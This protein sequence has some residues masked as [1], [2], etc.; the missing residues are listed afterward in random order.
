MNAPLSLKPGEPVG[1]ALRAI[2][3]QALSVTH[4]IVTD[5]GRD[6]ATAVHDFRK[7]MKRWRAL[8][9][10]VEPHLGERAQKLR[11]EARD[12]A[13]SLSGARDASSAL[14][15]LE[16]LEDARAIPSETLSAR[17]LQTI[18][19]RLSAMKARSER[20]AWSEQSRQDMLDYL[21]AASSDVARWDMTPIT[22]GD[23][24]AGLAGTYRRARKSIPDDWSEASAEALHELRQRVVIHRYQMELIEP[25]WPRLGRIWVEE[26]QRLRNRLGRHQDLAMLDRM[27]QAHGPLAPWRSRLAPVVKHAQGDDVRAAARTAA[28]LFA[29]PP[30]VFRRRIEALW[31][32][33]ADDEKPAH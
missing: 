1:D 7:M 30:K 33:Q 12:L 21:T 15:A 17:S 11:I 10:L 2:A 4:G 18:R 13:R 27:M 22:F 20:R 32:S 26:A 25:A 19:E 6:K 8:L 23:I 29:E 24:A 9:R 3:S 14:E 31:D 16:E 28:R 5:T